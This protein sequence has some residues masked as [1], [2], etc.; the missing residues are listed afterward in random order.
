MSEHLSQEQYIQMQ[1]ALLTVLY[2]PP[3]CPPPPPPPPPHTQLG[4]S[5]CAVRALVCRG[6]LVVVPLT[7]GKRDMNIVLVIQQGYMAMS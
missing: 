2:A 5:P 6:P 4:N 1:V 3:F 7:C